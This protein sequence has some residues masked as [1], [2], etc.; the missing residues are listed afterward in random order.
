MQCQV[1]KNAQHNTNANNGGGG[2]GG[3]QFGNNGDPYWYP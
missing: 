1:S 2:G 3:Q